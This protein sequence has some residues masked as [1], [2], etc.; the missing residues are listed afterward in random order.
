[1]KQSAMQDLRNDL[2][3]TISSSTEALEVINNEVIRLACQDVV[4]RTLNAII[5][6]IDDELLE[7]EKEQ[8]T[9]AVDETN[10]KWRSKNAEVLLSG[11]QYYN[12]TY[13]VNK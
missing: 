7:K 10:R 4:K 5:K 9:E 3:E 12:E 6:R 11:E 1:M 13:N 2:V 8:I